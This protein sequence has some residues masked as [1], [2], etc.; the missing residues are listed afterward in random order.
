M[1]TLAAAFGTPLAMVSHGVPIVV[2]AQDST[3]DMAAKPR[4]TA[5]VSRRMTAVCPYQRPAPGAADR[6]RSGSTAT[7]VDAQAV[8][9]S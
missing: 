3:V 8:G 1:K 2:S 7:T 4:K 5:A 9:G 6:E